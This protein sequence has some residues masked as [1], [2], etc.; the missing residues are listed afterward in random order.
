MKPSE[1]H[2]E[3]P[4]ISVTAFDIQPPVHDSAAVNVMPAFAN[5]RPTRA[6]REKSSSRTTGS[7][8]NMDVLR[9]QA[10]QMSI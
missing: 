4:A 6:A 10:A 1:N 5:L 8:L 3:L 7:A 9:R 2:C